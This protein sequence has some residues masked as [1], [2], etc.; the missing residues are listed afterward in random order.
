MKRTSRGTVLA[1]AFLFAYFWSPAL[2]TAAQEPR[3][4]EARLVGY[5]TRG[6]GE[7]EEKVFLLDALKRVQVI[8]LCYQKT[9]PIRP[10]DANLET[11]RPE[12]AD[13]SGSAYYQAFSLVSPDGKH[14]REIEMVFNT[15]E[16][17]ARPDQLLETM[18]K[19]IQ[20]GYDLKKVNVVLIPDAEVLRQS[21]AKCQ[22][23]AEAFVARLEV[24]K[25]EFRQL[26]SLDVR[27][28]KLGNW[29]EDGRPEYPDF[30]YRHDFVWT[31]RGKG[32]DKKSDEWCEIVL[33]FG[34]LTGMP[35]QPTEGSGGRDYPMQG[36]R[37]GWSTLS[38]DQRLDERIAEVAKELLKPID[39]FENE[40]RK[41][42]DGTTTNS[43]PK[44]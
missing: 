24:L 22:A 14:Y 42:K 13:L 16:Y 3:N 1:I 5:L 2:R 20:A 15:F 4:L 37:V 33:Q 12:E 41:K 39:D 30:L 6:Q 35:G 34:P 25:P 29:K 32:E 7:A 11:R 21:L 38:A 18:K 9:T 10:E 43:T 28:L 23:M 26:R 17:G 27:T 44:R 8:T 19:P 40:I 31:T 36:L